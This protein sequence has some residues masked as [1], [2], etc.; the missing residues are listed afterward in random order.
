MRTFSL[1][2]TSALM[3]AVVALIVELLASARTPVALA[4]A[5]SIWYGTLQANTSQTPALKSAHLTTVSLEVGWNVLQPRPGA[6]DL[7]AVAAARSQLRIWSAAGFR[8]HL[9]L[10]LQYAPDWVFALNSATRLRDQYGDVWK[11]ASASGGNFANAV[12]DNGVRTAEATYISL[13]AKALAPGVLTGVRVGG[14][15]AGELSY[16]PAMKNESSPSSRGTGLWMYDSS[17]QTGAP[18]AIRGW[19]PGGSN[20]QGQAQK[21][22]D[23]YFGMLTDYTG[24]LLSVVHRAFPA[25]DLLLMLPGWGLRPGQEGAAVNGDLKY[26]SAGETTNGITQGLDWTDQLNTLSAYGSPGIAYTTWLDGCSSDCNDATPAYESPAGYLHSLSV[27]RHLRLAGENTGG[28]GRTA[29]PLCLA[30]VRALG[31]VGMMWMS[32]TGVLG[33]PTLLRTYSAAT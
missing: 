10:G 29:M 16:P 33:D 13:L 19:K 3:A 32:A 15:N 22:L 18:A 7:T 6:L 14:L 5:P 9:D 28:N 11:P 4:S 12:F 20:T 2:Q 27:P 23:Y 26:T 21:A 31:M 25:A 8:V 30:R 1:R 17:A 24:W